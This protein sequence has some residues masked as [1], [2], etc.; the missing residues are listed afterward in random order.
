MTNLKN[1]KTRV[2]I[3]DSI[4]LNGGKHGG[5]HGYHRRDV[6]LH[7]VKL[8]N[9][10]MISGLYKII[11]SMTQTLQKGFQV[12]SEGETLIFKKNSTVIRF[13]E[14]MLNKSGKGFLLN[15]K[16]YKSATNVA[17]LGPVKRNM[18]GKASIHI[19]V[20]SV[21]TQYIIRTKKSQQR[22]F[23]PTSST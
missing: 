19:Q 17:L 13:Y 7:H 15:T 8:S 20:R 14:K 5:C 9:T 22:N 10:A 2:N 11:F 16:F 18:E 23:T 1:A 6:E 21:K 4:T 12:M 3:G